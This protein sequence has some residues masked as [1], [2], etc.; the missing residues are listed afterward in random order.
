MR[1]LHLL[2]LVAGVAATGCDHPRALFTDLGEITEPER[3][4]LRAVGL[5]EHARGRPDYTGI[6]RE[7]NMERHVYLFR[8]DVASIV[9]H[10]QVLVFDGKGNLLDANIVE[11]AVG[12]QPKAIVGVIPLRLEFV[13]SGI[14]HSEVV[15]QLA[16]SHDEGLRRLQEY[17]ASARVSRARVQDGTHLAPAQTNTQ[18]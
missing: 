14:E 7:G 12:Q 2:L 4:S 3:Q 17:P 18:K 1:M 6:W 8:N 11:V 16:Y 5:D 9:E 15:A 10:I 13:R